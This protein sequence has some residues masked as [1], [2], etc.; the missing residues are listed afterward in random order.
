M[1]META[2]ATTAKGIEWI[3]IRVEKMEFGLLQGSEAVWRQS[4]LVYF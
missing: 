4:D 1:M 2:V 3:W